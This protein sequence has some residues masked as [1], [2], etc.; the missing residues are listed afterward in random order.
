[1]KEAT[2]MDLTRKLKP[3]MRIV[4][5][6]QTE[7]GMVE[8]Y[9]ETAV[10]VGGRP[11]PFSAFERLDQDRLYVGHGGARYFHADREARTMTQEGEVRV[12]LVEERL[13]VGTRTIE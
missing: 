6:D 12:P 3:G 13:A 4:G 7:Y 11:I 9:D 5:P 1:M 2:S 10:Y 8:R